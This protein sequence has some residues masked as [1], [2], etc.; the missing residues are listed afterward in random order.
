[1]DERESGLSLS[2]DIPVPA[3]W[4]DEPPTRPA[5][6]PRQ[7]LLVR[8]LWAVPLVP[9][10][11]LGLLSG[12]LLA[13]A[14]VKAV[15]NGGSGT[16]TFWSSEGHL[17]EP[18]RQGITY[19]AIVPFLLCVT[20]LVATVPFVLPV[21][22]LLTR[23]RRRR[24]CIAAEVLAGVAWAQLIFVSAAGGVEP[25][26]LA[27]CVAFGYA[28]LVLLMDGHPGPVRIRWLLAG[29]AVPLIAAIVTVTPI[30]GPSD[31]AL[32]PAVCYVVLAV[33]L[34]GVALL[35]SIRRPAATV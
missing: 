9:L 32:W 33:Y 31:R 8:V 3:S 27:L 4:T 25:I 5:E 14:G 18:D 7:S 2:K 22:L 30:G 26:T 13:G 10:I 1:M 23:R 6:R 21:V 29:V 11:L 19:P 15:V 35:D 16:I 24:W 20:E 12:L 34:A 17:Y 28:T